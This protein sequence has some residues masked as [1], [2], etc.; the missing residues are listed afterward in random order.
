MYHPTSAHGIFHALNCEVPWRLRRSRAR[1][2]AILLTQLAL[3]IT[4]VAD[5]RAILHCMSKLPEGL[6]SPMRVSDGQFQK[7]GDPEVASH[8]QR[9][10]PGHRETSQMPE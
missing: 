2:L 10:A 9:F 4:R 3:G 1:R 6:S 7:T 5:H 8:F